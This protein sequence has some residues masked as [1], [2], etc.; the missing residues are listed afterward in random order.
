M[1]YAVLVV[2]AIGFGFTIYF[3]LS[4]QEHQEFQSSFES[5]AREV[6]ELVN[7]N[8]VNTFGQFRTLATAI[9][10]HSLSTQEQFPN[11]I[12]P[13]FDKRVSEVVELTAAEMLLWV[14]LVEKADRSKF[15]LDW[16]RRQAAVELDYNTRGWN[17]SGMKAVAAPIH[18][19]TW[20]AHVNNTQRGYVN[21]GFMEEIMINNGYTAG[22]LSAPVSQFGPRLIDTGLVGLDLYSH[23]TFKKEMVASVEYGVP[24][25]SEKEGD[26]EFLY[27]YIDLNDTSSKF[28]SFTLDEVYEDFGENARVV[29]F[30]V[31]VVPWNSFFRDL[32]PN[33]V[34]GLVM[35]MH[36]DCGSNFTYI[37]NGGKDDIWLDG[38]GHSSTY[39]EMAVE[40]KFF[41]KGWYCVYCIY[42]PPAS[43]SCI[44][45]CI[46]VCNLNQSMLVASPATAIS[47]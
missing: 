34:N 3:L 44:F 15:E 6:T 41:W 11:V 27:N 26:L 22:K 16:L 1:V 43:L 45:S 40:S 31:S 14:P 20:C 46:Y 28:R 13:Y 17:T 39:N 24:V 12:L 32:L 36:S 38:S 47:I 23:P 35:E 7:N 33:E 42:F 25:I 37:T 4:N 21:D 2:A 19:C 18:E 8:A 5:Y 29:G 10:S 9:T 30:V